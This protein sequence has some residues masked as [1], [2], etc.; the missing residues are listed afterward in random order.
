VMQSKFLGSYK[1]KKR[2]ALVLHKCSHRE[3]GEWG[4]DII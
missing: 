3:T 2:A 4:D 1:S